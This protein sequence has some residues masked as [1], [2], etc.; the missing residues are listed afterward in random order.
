MFQLSNHTSGRVRAERGSLSRVVTSLTTFAG[1]SR[2]IQFQNG[3]S[4]DAPVANN[5]RNLFCTYELPANESAR[6]CQLTAH[7]PENV[8]KERR[9]VGCVC[10]SL[11]WPIHRRVFTCG[12]FERHQDPY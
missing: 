2:I 4:E 10:L 9:K 8:P 11:R 6:D 12:C 5:I 1:P 3:G 7:Q